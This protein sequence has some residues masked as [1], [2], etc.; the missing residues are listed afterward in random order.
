M[1]TS[2]QHPNAGGNRWGYHSPE[3]DR[4][5]EAGRRA[6]GRAARRGP[7]AKVQARLARDLPIIPLWHE[8]NLVVMRRNVHGYRML[9]NARFDPLLRVTKTK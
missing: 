1:R 7:Y 8:E 2:A 5:L 6:R 4:W 9:P 3:V